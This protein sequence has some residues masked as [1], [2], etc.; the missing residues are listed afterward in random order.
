MNP[1]NIAVPG[2]ER[3]ARSIA[4]VARFA[5]IVAALA[6]AAWVA[7]QCGGGGDTNAGASVVWDGTGHVVAWGQRYQGRT[8]VL[9]H[10]FDQSRGEPRVLASFDALIGPPELVWSGDGFLIAVHRGDGAIAVIPMSPFDGAGVERGDEAASGALRSASA[11]DAV[12]AGAGEAG[13]AGET[14]AIADAA[15]TLCRAPVWAG[16][17]YGVAWAA[18]DGGGVGYYLARL[19]EDGATQSLTRVADGPADDPECLLTA[20]GDRIWLGYRGAGGAVGAAQIDVDGADI[21]SAFARRVFAADATDRSA[22]AA[23]RSADAATRSADAATRG[24]PTLVR[25]VAYRDGSALLFRPNPDAPGLRV[26]LLDADAAPR[27]IHEV[28]PEAPA[29]TAD[30]VAAARGYVV[31][32]SGERRIHV[33]GVDDD[34][35]RRSYGST[36]KRPKPSPVRLVGHARDCALTWTEMEGNYVYLL[37]LPGCADVGE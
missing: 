15:L 23:T 9:A 25:M 7:P 29:D 18:R 32:W 24:A 33:L 4:R 2:G 11:A 30:L 34:G 13:E 1:V 6:A 26:A 27:A 37:R 5:V 3:V 20:D 12:G 35:R 17:G 36:D 31:G 21:R 10:R 14:R 22:D 8:H 19:D 28:P 16:S